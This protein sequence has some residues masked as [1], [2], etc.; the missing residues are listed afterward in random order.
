[1]GG[2]DIASFK[3]RIEYR[4]KPL[5][6]SNV[7]YNQAVFITLDSSVKS[8]IDNYYDVAFV[9]D[10]KVLSFYCVSFDNLLYIINLNEI[11]KTHYVNIFVYYDR[12]DYDYFIEGFTTNVLG[13]MY[14][15]VRNGIHPVNTTALTNVYAYNTIYHIYEEDSLYFNY[16]GSYMC[17]FSS[18]WFYVDSSHEGEWYFAVDSN[19]A[20]DLFIDDSFV[21]GW[22]GGHD[23]CNCT[24]HNGHITLNEGWHTIVARHEEVLGSQLLAVYFRFPGDTVWYSFNK[25][26]IRLGYVKASQV[27]YKTKKFITHG[28]LD[29]LVGALEELLPG[30]SIF[31]TLGDSSLESLIGKNFGNIG[32]G[33]EQDV[34]N[35]KGVL[36]NKNITSYVYVDCVDSTSFSVFVCIYLIETNSSSVLLTLRDNTYLSV[37]TNGSLG[38]TVGSTSYNMSYRLT[39]NECT[40][41]AFIYDGTTLNILIGGDVVFIKNVS[42]TASYI[43]L[44]GVGSGR[45]CSCYFYNF[46][47]FDYV[48]SQYIDYL[49]NTFF[50]S[51]TDVVGYDDFTH[52]ILCST[53][54]SDVFINDQMIFMLYGSGYYK[55]SIYDDV[56]GN[57][58]VYDNDSSITVV[59]HSFDSVGDHSI[60]V[61]TDTITKY[62]KVRVNLSVDDKQDINVYLESG[63]SKN[64]VVDIDAFFISSLPT[65]QGDI[66]I[67]TEYSL[68]EYKS[69]LLYIFTEFY[70]YGSLYSRELDTYVEF[71]IDMSLDS[72]YYDVDVDLIFVDLIGYYSKDINCYLLVADTSDTYNDIPVKLV[73]SNWR[74]FD[75][76]STI[77]VSSALLDNFKSSVCLT[78]GIINRYNSYI[79]VSTSGIYDY[80]SS[81]ICSSSGIMNNY[82]DIGTT[83][84]VLNRYSYDVCVSD[85]I[86]RDTYFNVKLNSIVFDNFTIDEHDVTFNVDCYSVDISDSF[87]GILE[88]SIK[89]YMGGTEVSGITTSGIQNGYNVTWCYNLFNT[90]SSG[91]Y[92]FIVKATN[93]YGDSGLSS[94]FLRRGKRF[95]Y[96]LYHLTVHDYEEIIPVLLAAENECD[97]YPSYSTSSLYVRVENLP[98]RGL[99]ATITP[100]ALAHSDVNAELVC[101]SP[102]FYPGGYYVVELECKDNDGNTMP[103]L[104]FDFTIRADGL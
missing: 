97:I 5:N 37:D 34:C 66:N 102:N 83:S 2:W 89:V 60:I 44:G 76:N 96:N 23:A 32:S 68:D 29:M 95:Y 35:T 86:L 26:K 4:I 75:H 48:T 18:V 40:S 81:V 93:N 9:I 72:F 85:L 61:T 78:S 64:E 52:N 25:N 6:Y 91:V 98:S 100:V 45:S 19:D 3:K 27:C 63:A 94:F 54:P 42:I 88:S 33:L 69:F 16:D 82:I 79:S 74:Y 11:H 43:K 49:H 47:M 41:V 80:S 22:Y 77:I 57:Y 90:T 99:D 62:Y 13:F 71:Y 39:P 101:M 1:M 65:Y 58:I 103:T 104:V 21:V 87:Y 59:S 46:M 24:D 55:Y 36:T 7:S 28:V 30:L 14:D 53:Y 84:G 8:S 38:F 20:S 51:I 73:S 15:R 17:F 50:G 31:N 92:Q 70:K 67:L 10:G 12:V 56:A